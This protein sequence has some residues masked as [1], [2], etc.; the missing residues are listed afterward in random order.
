[1]NVTFDPDLDRTYELPPIDS[2]P[3]AFHRFDERSVWAVRAALAAERPL[4][5]RG[6]PGLGKSQLARA[7]AHILEVP[8]LYKVINARC[9]CGDLQYTYDAVSRLA[10]AQVAGTAAGQGV[11]WEAGLEEG[12]F[13][14]PGVLWWAFD[15]KSAKKQAKRFHRPCPE[16]PRP[17]KWT[18][19][20]GCVVLID[21]I[22]KPDS[23]LPN[24]LLESLGNIGFQVPPAGCSVALPTDAY[25]PLVVVTTNEERE[26]P[27]AFL[28]RCLV[29]QMRMPDEE[30][31]K[32]MRAADVE[33]AQRWFLEK[34]ARVHL[35]DRVGDKVY[36]EA[37]RQLMKD[38]KDALR[39]GHV[40]PGP[41]EY[42]D[43][44]RALAKLHPGD[45]K[46][47][48]TALGRIQDFALRKNP[49][50]PLP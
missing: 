36:E 25:P 28:R 16:P 39:F 26:L 5:V 3:K 20:K 18:P 48:L 41:A 32:R 12:R 4:L 35:A 29:L 24:S 50:E 30:E 44:L 40:R 31:A 37:A 19:G 42:L 33:E 21:E 38:R 2:W 45:E 17:A 11:D 15:W 6:E 49:E 23:D 47:Q 14:Q 7:A 43:L 22:D 8:F 34:R 10:Q 27:A 9:E 13:V 1:M 46:A